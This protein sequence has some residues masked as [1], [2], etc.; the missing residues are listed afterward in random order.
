[1]M[2]LG[3]LAHFS[4]LWTRCLRML[5]SMTQFFW[6]IFSLWKW[7]P[8]V[9]LPAEAGGKITCWW[10]FLMSER[11]VNF[12]S[13]KCPIHL[14]AVTCP[15][16]RPPSCDFWTSSVPGPPPHLGWLRV[17]PRPSLREHFPEFWL[18]DRRLS[19]HTVAGPG[20]ATPAHRAF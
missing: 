20:A 7:S 18:L 15:H 17:S 13:E 6:A 5:L 1:M 8:V 2:G 16:S 12:R 19:P 4:L 10:W 9:S 11:L 3:P 14:G